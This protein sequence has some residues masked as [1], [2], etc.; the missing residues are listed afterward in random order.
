MLSF[1]DKPKLNRASLEKQGVFY[2]DEIAFSSSD[3]AVFAELEERSQ[4]VLEK[5]RTY[6]GPSCPDWNYAKDSWQIPPNVDSL[7]ES[8]LD[9]T[10]LI[11]KSATEFLLDEDERDAIPEHAV[12]QDKNLKLL[13]NVHREEQLE[14]FRKIFDTCREIRDMARKNQRD[15]V[16]ESGWQRF[17]EHYIFNQYCDGAKP[18]FDRYDAH[19]ERSHKLIDSIQVP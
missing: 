1:S 11:P 8:L 6:L 14:V 18:I 5:V 2:L 16:N 13:S 17:M 7:R 10:C 12:F 3:R 19:S 4:H 9:C 15:R